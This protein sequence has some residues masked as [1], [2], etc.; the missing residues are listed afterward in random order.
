MSEPRSISRFARRNRARSVEQLLTELASLAGE[1][2][3]LRAGEAGASDLERNRLAIVRTQWDLS[4]A[5][6]ARHRPNQAAA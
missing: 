5:L 2:Q 1:R 3:S 4:H 6:I